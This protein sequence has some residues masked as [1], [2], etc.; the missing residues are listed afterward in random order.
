MFN[1]TDQQQAIRDAVRQLC[2]HFPDAYFQQVDERRG[3]P[4]EFVNALTQAGWVAALIPTDYGGSGLT[5]AQA[6]VIMEEIN[7]CVGNAGACHGQ[8]YVMNAIVRGGSEPQRQHYLPLIARG[9]LRIQSMAVTEPT[10]GSDTTR[11]KTMAIKRDGRWVVPTG[12]KCGSPA[13]STA[14]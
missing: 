8:M 3:Y 12:R 2:G 13:C 4:E 9:E 14:L 1:E 6:S 5:M 11:L 7:R 10:T